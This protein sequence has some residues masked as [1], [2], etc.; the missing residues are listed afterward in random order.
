[1]NILIIEA[2]T[3]ANIGSGALVENSL[4]IL[5]K[6]YPT[7]KLRVMAHYPKAFR[8]LCGVDTVEDV[9][10]YPFGQSRSKQLMWLAWSM[11]WMPIVWIAAI[12]LSN[13]W[14][15]ELPIIGAKLRDFGWA[16]IIVSVGAERINDKFF[17]NIVFSLYTYDLI[18]RMG[19]IMIIFPSTIGPFIFGWTRWLSARILRNV[20]LIYTRDDLSNET[21]KALPG[22]LPEKVINTADVAVL[23]D[24][25]SRDQALQMIP[26]K[27]DEKLVGISV[28]QWSYF[29]NKV[30]TPYSNYSAYVREMAIFADTIIDEYVVSVVL[31][32]TNYPE[33][34][35]REDDVATAFEVQ[36][37]MR[38]GNKVRIITKLPTPSQFKGMLACSEL[39][40]TTRMH[41]C[42][43]STGAFVPTISINYLF[44]LAE[45]MN[46]LGLSD[47]SIDIEEFCADRAL[48]A[49]RKMWPERA[50][51]R[52][53]LKGAIEE[54][55][56]NL[57]QSM[58]S[59]NAVFQG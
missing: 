7:S 29:K 56:T 45:Y 6:K 16:D 37:Q 15:A 40:V 58:E 5:Q 44:K 36:S 49:F 30:E 11:V 13:K 18:F 22:M 59:L 50:K 12:V 48:G 47:F 51:W 53:H 26:A 42:I 52:E 23:Q 1:M 39:N 9:F 41:A 2:Y 54:K 55:Q 35:C 31:Y 20:N 34:G 28:M 19:K 3:D 46:S 17:K 38:N 4:K 21:T 25:I 10:Q 27:P 33:K 14:L 57:Y 32:P 8:T 24:W 43:L